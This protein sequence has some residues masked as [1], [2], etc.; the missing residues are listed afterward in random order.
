MRDPTDASADVAEREW[1]LDELSRIDI[2]KR[3]VIV[4]HYYLDLPMHE[5]AE[6][7]D[8]PYGTAASRLH[9]GLE[10][11]RSSIDGAAIELDSSIG[12]EQQA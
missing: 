7:L 5:V 1:I 11:M 3:S 10:L 6:I 8:I 12:S 9:R 4:L 2:E